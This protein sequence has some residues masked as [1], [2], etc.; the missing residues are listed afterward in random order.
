MYIIAEV[1]DDS[2]SQLRLQH[3]PSL[4]HPAIAT[5]KM[6]PSTS[7]YL[8]RVSESR[9][10]YFID[11]ASTL[12]PSQGTDVQNALADLSLGGTQTAQVQREEEDNT[13]V[14][15]TC[16]EKGTLCEWPDSG[17]KQKVC[18]ACSALRKPCTVNG[19]PVSGQFR[20]RVKQAPADPADEL[21]TRIQDLAT[22]FPAITQADTE[23]QM[24]LRHIQQQIR[25]IARQGLRLKTR[26][27]EGGGGN[28]HQDEDQDEDAQGSDDVDNDGDT[29]MTAE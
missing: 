25:V 11:N 6:S 29:Q 20:K 23:L 1:L 5:F 21:S 8:L 24:A 27:G 13:R 26:Q 14:C 2:T 12:P 16:K 15:D 18:E 19:Q 9:L 10:T 3:P 28:D 22:T 7:K 17:K 4:L